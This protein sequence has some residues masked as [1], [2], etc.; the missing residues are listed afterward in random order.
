MDDV[1]GHLDEL[2]DPVA[3]ILDDCF[4]ARPTP[5]RRADWPLVL[6]WAFVL[7]I[8]GVILWYAAKL[9]QALV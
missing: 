5:P 9:I 1:K 3:S 7:L 8:D 2:P 4:R 6:F